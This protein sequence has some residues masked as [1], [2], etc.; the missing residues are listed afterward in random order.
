M[1]ITVKYSARTTIH[2]VNL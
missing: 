2:S 1:K